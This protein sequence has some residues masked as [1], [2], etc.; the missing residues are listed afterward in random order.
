MTDRPPLTRLD[1]LRFL[2][3]VQ[4]QD[5]ARTN[6]WIADEERRETERARGAAARPP[7]PDWL[8]ERG[9]QG[10]HAVYVHVGGCHMAGKRSR[11]ATRDQ[12]RQFLDS[13]TDAC[14]HCRPDTALGVLE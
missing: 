14:P 6:R 2:K 3:R 7:D 9:L 10:R 5:L 12:A 8:V 11:A 1:L 4:E 13:G